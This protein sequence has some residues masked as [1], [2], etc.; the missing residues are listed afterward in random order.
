MRSKKSSFLGSYP[1]N[2]SNRSGQKGPGHKIFKSS[3]IGLLFTVLSC[4]LYS[5]VAFAAPTQSINAGKSAAVGALQANGTVNVSYT[6]EVANE[7]SVGLSNLS[8]EDNLTAPSSLGSAFIHVVNAPVVTL[9]NAS[10]NSVAPQSNGAA[11]DG[12]NNILVGTDGFLAPGDSYSVTFLV[13]VNPNAT[14]APAILQNT[15]LAGATAPDS[16]IVADATDTNTAPDGSADTVANVPDETRGVP[17]V[18]TLPTS[19]PELGAVKSVINVDDLQADG[20]FNVTFKVLVENT[21]N[22]RLTKLT[23]TDDLASPAALGAAFNGVVAP[24]VVT[25]GNNRSGE[26][27]AP[28]SAWSAFTGTGS[29]IALL[30]GNDGS[31]DP[32]DSFE[33]V[34]TINV[35][36]GASG[37][38]AQL[39][40]TATAGGRAP[41]G[42][43]V[44][45][46]SNSGSDGAGSSNG[47]TPQSNP[48]GPGTPTFLPPPAP[49][50]APVSN[51][52]LGVVKS[53]VDIAP[54]HTDG[55]FDIT[56]N[57]LVEN[58]G[59]VRLHPL[60][61]TDDLAA[62][63]NLGSAFLEVVS[64]PVVTLVTNIS[65]NSTAPTSTGAAF[66]GIGAG[67]AL[68]TGNDGSL[69][70]GDRY[71]VTYIVTID[72]NASGAPSVLQNT[73][74]GGATAPDGSTV[75][76]DS[77]TGTDVD[78]NPTGEL[79]V[80]NPGGPGVPTPITPPPVSNALLGVVKSVEAIGEI[81][82][83]GSFDVQYLL[84][85][86][87]LGDVILDRLTLSDDLSASNQF[88]TAFVGIT[89]PPVISIGVDNS[90][91]AIA[92]T[93]NGAAFTGDASGPN[94]F[95]GN[96][97][98]FGPGDQIEVRFTANVN[99][100]LPGAPESLSNI[101]TATGSAPDG[102]VVRDASDA[103]TDID[104]NPT[105][106]LPANNPGGPGTPT[107]LTPPASNPLLGLVKSVE[108]IGDIQADGSFDVQYLLLI[109]NLGGVVL[110]QLTL[111]DDLS[112]SDQLGAAFVG[113]TAPPV[114]S[115]GV[116]NS[117]L[118]IA[119]TS[120]G[121]AFTGD[122][123]GPNLFV[124]NDG[125]LGPGDAIEV[126][127]S[128]NINATLP[129]APENLS[130]TATA[131]GTTPGGTVVSDDS[132]TGTDID[133]NPTGEVPGDNPGGPGSPTPIAP[134]IGNAQIG[135]TKGVTAIGP[136]QS[137]G[138]F[139][140]SYEIVV[141][142]TG[143]VPLSQLRLTDNLADP[144]N[145][146]TAFVSVSQPPVVELTTNAN[147]LSV[148]PI[149]TGAGFTG[150]A[151]GTDLLIGDATRL[152]AGDVF[153]VNFA[154]IIN[155]NA[156][157]APAVLNNTATASGL[158]LGSAVPVTDDTNT[159]TDI[160]GNPTGE[161]PTDN[162]GGP[163]VPTPVAPPG[164][165][166]GIGIAKSAEV[167]GLLADGTFDVTFTLIVENTG[168]VEL[169]ALTLVDELSSPTNLGTAF[170]GLRGTPSLTLL[171]T[172]GASVAP[173]LNTAFDGT[174]NNPNLLIGTD[175]LLQPNDQYSV[176][177]TAI[178]NADAPGAPAEL[179]NQALAGGTSPGGQIPEDGSD[180]GSDPDGPNDG[181]TTDDPTPIG[182]PV[183]SGLLLTKTTST[184]T[185]IPGGFASYVVTVSNPSSSVINGVTIEDD[186]PGGFSFVE[187]SGQL[188][189]AGVSTPATVT[190]LDPISVDLG[191]VN[192]GETLSFS[193]LTRVSAGVV[194][195]EHVN[196][197]GALAF[198]ILASNQST[199]TVV[200]GEDAL[201][202][203]TRVVGKVWEDID[204]DGWQDSARATG[205]RI[206]GG[207]FGEGR[208][209][210]DLPGRTS[211]SDIDSAPMQRIEVPRQWDSLS[212]VRLTTREGSVLT[213]NNQGA[214]QTAHKRGIRKGRNAQDLQVK[215]VKGRPTGLT[216]R[217]T[218]LEIR[219]VGIDERGIPG[220]RLA[221]VEGLVIETDEFG[222]YHVEEI[223]NIAFDIGSNFIIKVDPQS[224]PEGAEFTTEN[225]RVVRLT[226]SLMS[227][228]NFGIRIP[229]PQWSAPNCVAADQQP[230]GSMAPSREIRL[231][232]EPLTILRFDSGKSDI[233]DAEMEI[234]RRGL[235]RLSSQQNV[236]LRFSGH[237]DNE[238]LAPSTKARYKD[239]Q[240]LSIARAEE[241]ASSVATKL[242]I[243]LNDIILAGF[244]DTQPIADNS[245]P[246]GRA[247]NRRVTVEATYEL[248]FEPGFVR[249][250]PT[251]ASNKYCP[252]GQ[253]LAGTSRNS[254]SSGAGSTRTLQV[255]PEITETFSAKA[256][257]IRFASGKSD[258]SQAALDELEQKLAALADKQNVR[259]RFIGHTDNER[260]SARTASIYGSNLGLSEA[261][262]RQ[263]ADA[264]ARQLDLSGYK[265]EIEGR[266]DQEP[267]ASNDTPEG[268][269]ANRRVTIELI[270]DEVRPGRVAPIERAVAVSEFAATSDPTHG[271]VR[272]I[273]DRA[274]TDPR[275]AVTAQAEQ[276]VEGTRTVTFYHYSNYPA[277]IKELQLHIYR[278]SDIDRA[279]PIAKLTGAPQG[280]LDVAGTMQ[281][282]TQGLRAGDRYVYILSAIGA[283]GQRD[284]T[285]PR[286]L[287][288]LH[289]D[290]QRGKAQELDL[291]SIYGTNALA[292]QTIPVNGGRVRV[293][294]FDLAPAHELSVAG[295][296]M[297][298]DEEGK[299]AL[300]AHLPRGRYSLPV[301]NRNPAGPETQRT[302]DV[303]VSDSYLFMVGLANVTFGGNDLDD[304]V[305]PLS[306]DD[307][308]GSDTYTT[309]RLAFYLK[310][311][312]R[313]KY[314]ITAQLDTTEDELKDLTDN[315]Q[316]K[317]PSSI[318]RRL[319]PDTYYPVYGDDSTTRR[320]TES[321]G[322]GY[323]R[324]DWDKS[325]ALWGN[326]ET[327]LTGN[328]FA[329]YNRSLY[330][331]QLVYRTP[332]TTD[333]GEERVQVTAFVSE[334]ESV[335][336][337]NEFEATGGSLYYL[338]NTDV[339]RGSQ[340]L[341]I[342]L[343]RRDTEQVIEQLPLQLGEDYEF[344]HIQGRI[345]LNRPLSQITPERTNPIIRDR[346]LEGD[347]VFLVANYEYV[348]VGFSNN[349]L[350][351]GVRAK[352]WVTDALGLGGTYVNEARAGS[353]YTLAGGDVT[354]R[355][356]QGTYLKL[357]AATS[358]SSQT[359]SLFSQDGGLTFS[360]AAPLAD[361]DNDGNAYGVEARVNLQDVSNF[362]GILK[363]WY[364][365]RE[366]GFSSSRE[367]IDTVDTEIIGFEGDVKVTDR[368]T[369]TARANQVERE[370]TSEDR[371]LSLQGDFRINNRLDVGVEVR[372]ER[373]E[374]VTQTATGTELIESDAT[375]I[376]GRARYAIDKNNTAYVEGQL[377][378]G[379]S[380]AFGSND[381]IAVGVETRFSENL[382]L[383]LEV[384]DGDRGS[385]IIGSADY[386]VS[387]NIV[388][389]VG[390]GFGDGAYTTAGAT[391]DLDNGYQVYGSYGIDPDS[392]LDRQRHITTLGQ[393]LAFGNGAKIY[394][395]HQ[396][397]RGLSENGISNLFGLEYAVNEHLSL[398][399]TYQTGEIEIGDIDTQRD[400]A[401]IGASYQTERLR[402]GSRVEWRQD[403]GLANEF[404]QWL[405]SN[406]VEFKASESLR[407]LAKLNYSE[408]E[409]QLT[410][411]DA[412]RL[413]E[414]SVGFAYRPVGSY[415]WAVLG[416]YTYLEDLVA[417]QQ[418]INR[419]DQRSH[420]G[421]L[422]ALYNLNAR[423][424]F[425]LKLAVRRGEIRLNR[426]SGPWFDSGLD[427]AV[428]RV[429]YH[430]NHK[431][432]G[433]LEYRYVANSELN[434][435]RSGALA[436]L[437]RHIGKRLKLGAGYNF[438]DYSDDLS[439]LDYDNGGWF[440]D[441]IGKW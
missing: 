272:A 153:I 402:L 209:L 45:D 135:A 248:P 73:A 115:I 196:T 62:P 202:S 194:T 319:E 146:G 385:A 327:G 290:E 174:A 33:V 198:G 374:L 338:R 288:V 82:T 165:Q 278:A 167:A 221:T 71:E 134:P 287:N 357:E 11:Y 162:P 69:E 236:R 193:Y 200:V 114:I 129:G 132:N 298:L 348:P 154:V 90:G 275:L 163:G 423:W 346:A 296:A 42:A 368:L 381:L 93:S 123:S 53:V 250:T 324:V 125:Q 28:T 199:A 176:V 429:R 369:V 249:A 252:P 295:E 168:D 197:A 86:E 177:F 171:N 128:A 140:V 366:A 22:Q 166:P 233:R 273:E 226:Q 257:E 243:D 405:T 50:P 245:T 104:G 284:V 264:V 30:D 407:L 101:A 380:A 94:L 412:A 186:L 111:S 2:F 279:R 178:V 158:P 214:V 219:N 299:F 406:N 109:E 306:A 95:V 271:V 77:N 183:N 78:G 147:G 341:W 282:Q 39:Q 32:G 332:R 231:R 323:V 396:F 441:L 349:D 356:G 118:P 161:L 156:D 96:D 155:P 160:D 239:N 47:E 79:P 339:V 27:V 205:L 150:R 335:A 438:T 328:E 60:S 5:N 437:Y 382:G 289:S 222:R 203:T 330:G 410:G 316:R 89:A 67:A 106:E 169:S 435:E 372:D 308:F 255:A 181:G 294:G 420:I 119:P 29:G 431:W 303:E 31:L 75:T 234:I 145:L 436:G 215:I 286:T 389:D 240:G 265:L 207:P 64:A 409:D 267:I 424:E 304:V 224:L 227:Q 433:L 43:V 283:D 360:A 124:G 88:G 143:E 261:R 388:L 141:Q 416:R 68:L 18:I 179:T 213:I 229:E 373:R 144:A 378:T 4:L 172:S 80:D 254:G 208:R 291:D 235:A 182:V 55:T 24:P 17:T 131:T 142:N 66:T 210:P 59:N 97:G 274:I 270:Y 326:F 425:G 26:D 302:L 414:G 417:P 16:T 398:S 232:T 262:A 152:E 313:G 91:V 187:D 225:P 81:Q 411:D 25:L 375:L 334:P 38:P 117:G 103:G 48:G 404:E 314:L 309:G 12:T 430:L 204:G 351:T 305:E 276:V 237:T 251:P 285:H 220:A 98:R 157:G 206:S 46:D 217:K 100:N 36:P 362:Q 102:T 241:V 37:A 359:T 173:T 333:Y 122:A 52:E 386:R 345:L 195:G 263:V 121:A 70:P 253:V 269:A 280:Q 266:G 136:L 23:L 212:P 256:S 311:K 110:N 370:D 1:E 13:N 112:A 358:D 413:A 418:I 301:V 84:L 188:L 354:W 65:G 54:P 320:D 151:G 148:A 137:N 138:S 185:V 63:N 342:E 99:A 201:L 391:V 432:D 41:N 34:F 244:G 35:N 260:L 371:V 127:F 175:G 19:Q 401:S 439:N 297:M 76:D 120:N 379:E 170:V 108:T 190:G 74:T 72:P 57:V 367:T 340:K 113:I 258:L 116:N 192:P 384:S 392:T 344:D 184:P 364:K 292:N 164:E 394:Q 223:E 49:A 293:W 133:G 216:R 246:E 403:E 347:R 428:G 408:T 310:G 180:S 14:N 400:A 343:R 15:A 399:T 421:S 387:D 3:T 427:V 315:L 159:S 139:E 300:E 61:L 415:R 383:G 337:Y 376:G 20:T 9:N 40:N 307:R 434:D 230:V 331:A 51:P 329:Q 105:G 21:G 6:I 390:A 397:T 189:R 318:F 107:P 92:P 426:D 336:A 363:A 130:N 56:F 277:F 7:G 83:D 238:G 259:V 268:M 325:K 281:W 322:A 361:A 355:H 321:I 350:T 353:D 317:D 440:V 393:R 8:L 312:V 247:Q 242:G 211:I 10:G 365:N 85:I 58:T 352:L 228:A 191:S 126:R 419:P 422:E 44:S 377:S 218:Y 149:S 87:N 395:E